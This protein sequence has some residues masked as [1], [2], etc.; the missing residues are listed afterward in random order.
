MAETMQQLLAE[1]IGDTGLAVLYNDADGG[2][3]RWSWREY[4]VRAA[5]HGAAV[6]A[7][8]DTGRPLHVGALLGNT[9]RCS[10]RSPPPGWAATSC[11]GST[12]PAAVR[13]SPGICA[14]PTCRSCSSMPNTARCCGEWTC[15]ASRS[16]T[17]TSRRG[18][19]SAL[20]PGYSSRIGR[21]GPWIRS[22]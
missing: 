3:I 16:S 5:R 13:R 14:P 2:Q 19:T 9:P 6:L 8:A 12:T 4:L 18:P 1:R 11:A 17:S 7:R 15:P 22:C 20:R 21:S 10:P